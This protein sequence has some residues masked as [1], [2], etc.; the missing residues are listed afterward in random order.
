MSTSI[1]VFPSRVS[2]VRPAAAILPL[3]LGLLTAL[4]VRPAFEHA[5]LLWYLFEEFSF[6][7]LVVPMAVGLVWWRRDALRRGIADGSPA[8]LPI[9]LGAVALTIFGHRANIY[10][11]SGLAVS[12]LLWG[13]AIYLWGWAA[14]RVLAFP[15]W[16]LAF[17]LM[18]YR[19]LL[20]SLGFAM[21]GVTAAGSAALARLIGIPVVQEGLTLRGDQFAFV[22]AQECSGMSSMLSLLAL[23]ALWAYV[24]RGKVPAR[25]S[26]MA[27][28]LPL[29]LVANTLRV[30]LVLL[31]AA[32]FG[33][34]AATGFFHG[35]SSL[36]L[37][38]LSLAGL[39]LVSRL[40][41]CRA[42]SLT[43]S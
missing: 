7:F 9:V 21:Q 39:L 32:W 35:A 14:G 13:M 41:G 5:M 37:F 19:G 24:A 43:Q 1:A 34:D 2:R 15:I 22:V 23:A 42:P 17:G 12:P 29:V 20:D 4:F 25:L 27:S 6:G 11:V 36:I 38:G 8:G 31:V 40:V 18:V 26:I 10:T 33:E 28:V 16:F 30:T 3:S